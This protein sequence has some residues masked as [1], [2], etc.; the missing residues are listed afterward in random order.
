MSLLIEEETGKSEDLSD[1][2]DK[3]R[4]T[5]KIQVKFK[6]L[7]YFIKFGGITWTGGTRDISSCEKPF[8]IYF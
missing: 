1:P 8:I 5:E 7:V 4:L 2:E 6:S 3:Y